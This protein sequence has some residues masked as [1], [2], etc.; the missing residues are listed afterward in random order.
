MMSKG[1]PIKIHIQ[2]DSDILVEPPP[3]PSPPTHLHTHT[4]TPTTPSPPLQRKMAATPAG[5]LR[6]TSTPC[7]LPEDLLQCGDHCLREGGAMGT[8][9]ERKLPSS[10]SPKLKWGEAEIPWR[11][12]IWGDLEKCVSFWS[13]LKTTKKGVESKKTHPCL[14]ENSLRAEY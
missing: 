9:E 13:P 14:V 1:S 8:G 4:H 12:P 2:F 10:P 11:S 7:A 3:P 5:F 6:S